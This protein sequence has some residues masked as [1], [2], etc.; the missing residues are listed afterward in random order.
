LSALLILLTTACSK[1]QA[2]QLVIELPE[3]FSGIV[4]VQLGVRGAPE[5]NREGNGY[6]ITVPPDGKVLTSTMVPEIQPTFVR[7]NSD[8]VW[9]YSRSVSKTG[10]GYPVGG[11]IE[12]FVGTKE[13]YETFEANKHKSGLDRFFR[14]RNM[15]RT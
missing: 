6:R 2:S 8:R 4:Q 3:N 14:P 1:R 7:A 12:F 9:G 11:V 10:D 13:Q 15:D 5:L